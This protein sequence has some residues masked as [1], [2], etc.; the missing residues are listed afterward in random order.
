ML[1]KAVLSIRIPIAVRLTLIFPAQPS[2]FIFDLPALEGG[3]TGKI[4]A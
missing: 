1:F 3:R 4:D 2:S